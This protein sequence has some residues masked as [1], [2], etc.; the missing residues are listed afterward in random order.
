MNLHVLRSLEHDVKNAVILDVL[1]P[2]YSVFFRVENGE[3]RSGGREREP[4]MG[5]NAE[6]KLALNGL[7][8][9]LWKVTLKAC[10]AWPWPDE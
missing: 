7:K 1:S 9:L 10:M 5:S 2:L 3:R 6:H 4:G 8:D